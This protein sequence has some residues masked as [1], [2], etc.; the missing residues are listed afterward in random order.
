MVHKDKKFIINEGRAISNGKFAYGGFPRV[1]NEEGVTKEF[2]DAPSQV[3]KNVATLRND[4]EETLHVPGMLGLMYPSKEYKA[5]ASAETSAYDKAKELQQSLSR[6]R[7]SAYLAHMQGNYGK[8]AGHSAA[9]SAAFQYEHDPA[10]LKQA[11]EASAKA[12]ELR[13]QR[14]SHPHH[15]AFMKAAEEHNRLV[16][17]GNYGE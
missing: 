12:I 3:Q 17:G 13:K 2:E 11:E 7:H 15:G 16:R 4:Q 10:A 1:L 8:G 6:A 9:R 5:V 14:E